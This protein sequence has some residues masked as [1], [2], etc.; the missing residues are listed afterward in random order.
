M[1]TKPT[2][3]VLGAGASAPYDFPT[4]LNTRIREE[5]HPSQSTE[6]LSDIVN[7]GVSAAH[8]RDFAERLGN[9]GQSVDEFIVRHPDYREVG[10][11]AIA[12][13]VA[14][15]EDERVLH[16]YYK[17]SADTDAQRW[18]QYC[19]D[20]LLRSSTG[21]PCSIPDNKLTV[22]TFNFDR[23]FERAFF[24][25]VLASCIRDF[26]PERAKQFVEAIP[27][28]HIHGQLGLPGWLKRPS[29]SPDAHLRDYGLLDFSP[30]ALKRCATQVRI[31]DDE[32]DDDPIVGKARE[33]LQRAERV[34]FLGFSYHPL[35]LRKLRM[36]TWGGP[37]AMFGTA[38]RLSAGECNAVK[39][40]IRSF[41]G[42]K[43]YL[44]PWTDHILTFLRETDVMHD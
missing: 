42:S 23:S 25:F 1:I 2:V 6:F 28:Y 9:S 18:Y 16:P 20:K 36:D 24:N 8:V 40:S 10:K 31:V 34:C 35:N 44:R 29:D 4:D 3:F 5:I 17:K 15:W 43:I 13:A 21:G 39:A 14:P 12:R 33:A 26:D 32:V 11:I 38:Y 41:S 19:F 27:I 37:K 7:C 30:D 22:V